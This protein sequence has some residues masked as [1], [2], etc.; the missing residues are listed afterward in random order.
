MNCSDETATAVDQEVM[1]ILKECYDKA[2]KLLE[3]NKDVLDKIAEYLIKEETIT[4]K[5]FMKIYREIKGI[6]EEEVTKENNRE[7]HTKEIPDKTKTD[8]EENVL[9]EKVQKDSSEYTGED[10]IK[11][12]KTDD[13]KKEM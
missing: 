4:G 11:K 13:D 9:D 1:K 6:S 10:E 12:T 3:E 7:E 8:K 5:E 2:E